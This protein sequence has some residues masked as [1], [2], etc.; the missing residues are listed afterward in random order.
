MAFKSP[1]KT[2]AL[3]GGVACPQAAA[4]GSVV[5]QPPRD[6]WLHPYCIVPAQSF[7]NSAQVHGVVRFSLA[8]IAATAST[9]TGAALLFHV[10]RT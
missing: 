10:L 4:D 3:K 5:R 6:R 7:V 9:V 8:R 1:V 2:N